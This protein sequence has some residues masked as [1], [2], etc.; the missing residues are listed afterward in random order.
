MRKEKFVFWVFIVVT[1]ILSLNVLATSS[2]LPDTVAWIKALPSQ[3]LQ[4]WTQFQGKNLTINFVSENTPPTAAL[5]NTGIYK[6][7]E[8]LTGIKVNIFMSDLGAVV[9][10]CLVDF[11]TQAGQYQVIYADPYQI[12]APMVSNFVPLN[13]FINDPSLPPIPGGLDDFIQGDVIAGGYFGNTL[14]ALPYDCPTMIW[15]Y[16]KDIFNNPTYRSLF[17]QEM[18]YDWMPGPDKTWEQYY[19]IANWIN[20]KVKQGIIKGVEYGTGQQ[21]LEYDSLM[22]DFSNILYS[23][24]ANYFANPLV[25]SYGTSNP[26]ACTLDS[27]AAIAAATFYDKLVKIAAPQSTSWDWS[28]LANA[29][30]DGQIAMCPEWHE[31]AS[32]FENPSTSKVAGEVGYTIL[33]KGPSGHSANIWGGTNLAINKWASPQLQ[34]AGWLFILWVTSPETQ[35]ALLRYGST[36]TRYSVYNSSETKQLIADK[37]IGLAYALEAVE[38][39]WEPSNAY[40]RPKISQWLQCD[41]V[42]YTALSEMLAGQLTPTQA[43]QQATQ[44]INEITGWSK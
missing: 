6:Q 23:F 10:K 29:F 44:Q 39:A 2:E 21:A 16:R 7:F 35:Q 27:T 34:K 37:S 38:Q 13:Q 19:Q 25:S 42:V 36:P 20:E 28:G 41:T 32:T 11:S 43:M 14:Y 30:E 4:A 24:G 26:G 31:F 17:K 8:D 15:M 22:C 33:P 1:A 9:S 40:Y 5:L 3:Q 18:G 12:L